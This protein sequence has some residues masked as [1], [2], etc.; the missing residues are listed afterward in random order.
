MKNVILSVL[1]VCGFGFI[2]AQ[3]EEKRDTIRIKTMNREI[4]IK[5]DDDG[6][7]Q[8]EVKR[9]RNSYSNLNFWQGLDFGVN[10][11]FMDDDFGINN[12]P[13]NIHMELNYGRSFI[14]NL[15]FAEYHT[16]LIGEKFRVTTGLGLRFNRYA[17]KNRNTTLKF[18]DTEVFPVV[19]SINSFDKNF[20]NITYL[21]A[22]LFFTL[23][24]GKNPHNSIRIS[25]GA[26]LNYRIGS[27]IKQRYEINGQKVRE[28]NRG[29]YH[30]NP[31]LLDAG[32]RIGFSDF[33][34]FANYGLN[35]LF[36]RNKGPQ[37]TPFSLGLSWTL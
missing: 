2:S 26:V 17:F 34:V 22:P 12:D 1:V 7:S 15:N 36:E 19:D 23:V 20:M 10:G 35:Y 21:S 25:A 29:H 4:T 24:P 16:G 11:Y 5:I 6:S 3:E 33:S 14:L 37:Y 32:V 13:N 18:N 8:L 30:I 27:R 9:R 31:F 28:R